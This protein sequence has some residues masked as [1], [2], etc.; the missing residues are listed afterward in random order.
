MQ[1]LPPGRDTAIREGQGRGEIATK[2]GD[3]SKN[4]VDAL[5]RPTDFAPQRDLSGT[6]SGPG[7]YALTDNATDDQF[8]SAPTRAA[9]VLTV[10][11]RGLP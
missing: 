4:V 10:P 5:A 11:L 8:V 9:H 7:Y 3:M 2:G 1:H 6:G